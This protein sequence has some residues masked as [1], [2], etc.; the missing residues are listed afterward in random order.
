MRNRFSVDGAIDPPRNDGGKQK[1]R[2]EEILK[3]NWSLVKG[4]LVLLLLV[5]VDEP[6][7]LY[8]SI[9][10]LVAFSSRDYPLS[11]VATRIEP[12]PEPIAFGRQL[13]SG[14]QVSSFNELD[15]L[16]PM[17]SA[18]HFLCFPVSNPCILIGLTYLFLLC[19]VGFVSGSLVHLQPNLMLS[20]L[21]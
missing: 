15:T 2:V 8:S 13:I 18:C 12:T 7:Y 1:F 10:V 4:F 19:F 16:P 21:T 20:R 6:S 3:K 14:T 11:M 17:K 9:M 5:L